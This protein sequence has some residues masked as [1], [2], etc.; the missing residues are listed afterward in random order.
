MGQLALR[1]E[2][3]AVLYQYNV[4][5]TRGPRKMTAIIPAVDPKDQRAVFRPDNKVKAGCRL[6][7]SG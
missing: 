2:L 5:G 4:L 1:T 3:G 7:T 6:N